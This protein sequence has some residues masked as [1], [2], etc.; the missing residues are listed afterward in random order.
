MTSNTI[1]DNGQ[2]DADVIQALQDGKKIEAI[3]LLREKE[4]LDL[5]DAKDK[6][7]LYMANN[8]DSLPERP[9]KSGMPIQL[10]LIIFV[11]CIAYLAYR[12]FA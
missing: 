2:L 6:V 4:G 12:F 9:T 1:E 8:R 5:R 3:K 11:L 7:E 10:L